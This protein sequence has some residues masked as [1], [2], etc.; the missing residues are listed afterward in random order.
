MQEISTELLRV[1]ARRGALETGIFPR[2]K[3]D[4]NIVYHVQIGI[5][6]Y[7][8]GKRRTKSKYATCD[9]LEEARAKRDEFRQYQARKG[10]K[11]QSHTKK[12]EQRIAQLEQEVRDLRATL[13]IKDDEE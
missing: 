13:D 5:A 4:G 7:E 1:M 6:S 8:N 10:Q 2:L 9:T 12:L 11:V 3:E